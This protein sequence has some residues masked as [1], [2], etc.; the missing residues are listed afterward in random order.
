MLVGEA[1]KY[2]LLLS[3]SITFMIPL[4]WMAVSG[5]KTEDQVFRIPPVWIP[6]PARW[7]NY[8]EA[9]QVDDFTLFLFNTIFR[10]AIP[11]VF[12]VVISNTL[13][14]YSFGRLR[15]PGRDILFSICLVTM[16]IP[17][18][19]TMVPV[20]IIFKQLDWVN[21]YRPLIIPAFFASAYWIFM[22]RQFF[23]TIPDELTDAARIDGA[24][25]FQSLWYIVLPLV[26]PAIAVVALFSFMDAWNNFMGPLIYINQTK[27]YP[28]SLGLSSLSAALSQVGIKGLAY[29]YLMAV[30]TLVT[31]PIIVIFFFTQ[32]TFIE[33][34]AL[35]GLKG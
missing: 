13:V 16:M 34:I 21:S 22:L 3:L 35:T 23:R 12:A 27:L 29:P 25:E 28:L 19:V 17:A 30:S 24:N 4:F 18:Q 31:L 26:K 6:N 7:I 10:Y 2:L 5:L 20:F 11:Y 32:R 33:G 1:A 9:W 15:W 8:I 14:A